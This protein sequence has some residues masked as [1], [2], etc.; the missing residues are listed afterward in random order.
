MAAV[1]SSKWSPEEKYLGNSSHKVQL[2]GAT[3]WIR[4]HWGWQDGQ[5]ACVG[6]DVRGM[7]DEP[8]LGEKVD[9]E[10]SVV[11]SPVVR[12]ARFA[13][14]VAES[15][16]AFAWQDWATLARAA[17]GTDAPTSLL[18]R[19][20]SI[21]SPDA[22]TRT[23]RGPKPMLDDAVLQDVVA[24]AYLAA[25]RHPAQA[26]REVLEREGFLPAPV[27]ADQ[28]RKAVARARAAGY[29]PP[30]KTGRGRQ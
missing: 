30:A 3:Y 29:L 16:A 22:N 10:W 18:G 5:A 13:E 2:H 8:V 24:P 1:P 25:G 9:E 27:S 7:R 26:V 15:R 4:V 19:F 11:T 17:H 21:A 6:F 23:R 14:L 28:A 20:A 12:A